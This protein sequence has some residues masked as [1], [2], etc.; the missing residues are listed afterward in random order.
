MTRRHALGVLACGAGTA[1]AAACAPT[2]PAPSAS[3]AATAGKAQPQTGGTLNTVQVSDP[4]SADGH[5]SSAF[6]SFWQVYDRLTYYPDSSLAPQPML[7]E[8]WDIS[9]DGKQIKLNLRKGVTFHSGRD[10][11]S[12][13]VKYN[14]LRVRD[15]KVGASAIA[16]LSKWFTDIQTPDKY[17]AVLVSESPRPAAF[18]VFEY[19]NIVD[20][21]TME[22]PDAKTKAVGT[23]PFTFVEW[24]Q[25]LLIRFAKNKNYWQS[26]TPYLDDLV[27]N[28]ARDPQA[29]VV[30]LESGAVDAA[31]RV[32]LSDVVRLQKDPKYQAIVNQNGPVY[33]VGVN[34]TLKPLDNKLVR[35]A[36][37]YAIDRERFTQTILQGIVDARELP[38]PRQSPVFEAAKDTTYAFDLDKAKSLLAQASV[39]N[40]TLD[41]IWVSTYA[42]IKSFAEMYQA[43]LAKIGVATTLKPLEPG[44]WQTTSRGLQYG[45]NLTFTGPAA[46]QPVSLASSAVFS[47]DLS[48]T[49][50]KD[51]Q[52]STLVGAVGAE[53]D[54]TKRKGLYSQ[55][56]DLLLDQSFAMPLC[57][58]PTNIV[59]SARVHDVVY[60]MHEAVDYSHAWIS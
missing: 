31:D 49:G 53:E 16:T 17:T 51:D 45:L 42:D 59:V 36:L 38:W 52:Y 1:F 10:F 57:A 4:S 22:G 48:T 27:V 18:D 23:G 5:V 15:P 21:Q 37:N 34:T 14:L 28:I 35:Q 39:S 6:D 55:L 54:A 58:N 33:L 8:S 11:T 47:P 29:M 32:P 3:P 41:L 13:D 60:T 40:L 7:A 50:F 12:E 24:Q 20:S 25:G 30:Q 19:L 9:S 43:D 2:A 44:V 56:N 46:L 26:G